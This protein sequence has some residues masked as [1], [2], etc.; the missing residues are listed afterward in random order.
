MTSS[1]GTEVRAGTHHICVYPCAKTSV[2]QMS[3]TSWKAR[4]SR[5]VNAWEAQELIT[6]FR[7]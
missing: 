6:T 3:I 1:P 2:Y 5:W 4:H 7:F